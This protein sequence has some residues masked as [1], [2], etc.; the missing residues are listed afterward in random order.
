MIEEIHRTAALSFA[1]MKLDIYPVGDDIL[2]VLSGGDRPHIGCAVLAVPR[3]SLKGDGTP[4][5]TSSVINITGHK[6][7]LICRIIAEA[8][9]TEYNATVTCTGG[10]HVDGIT[11]E[12]IRE[13]REAAERLVSQ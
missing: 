12:Q 6:D 5:A 7:E 8:L 11:E 13:V 10:F 4:A 9:C 2:A 1:E 3:K